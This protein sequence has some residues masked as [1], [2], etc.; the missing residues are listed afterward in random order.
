MAKAQIVLEIVVL[1]QGT[2]LDDFARQ[3]FVAEGNRALVRCAARESLASPEGSTCKLAV[4]TAM[5]RYSY[6]FTTEQLG[7]LADLYVDALNRLEPEA[8][9]RVRERMCDPASEEGRRDAT[10]AAAVCE[11]LSLDF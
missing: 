5:L 11:R 2:P 4:A 7:V 10:A 1:L 8:L 6:R 9:V 3:N